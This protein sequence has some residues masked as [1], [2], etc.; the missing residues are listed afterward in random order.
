[1]EVLKKFRTVDNTGIIPYNPKTACDSSE[2]K[3]KPSNKDL[4]VRRA[5][6]KGINL[7]A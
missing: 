7:S 5:K 1:M 2:L 4:W 6:A 3:K